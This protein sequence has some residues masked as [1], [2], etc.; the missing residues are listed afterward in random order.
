MRSLAAALV[1][2]ALTASAARA[3]DE[4]EH[5]HMIQALAQAAGFSAEA[6]KVIADGSWSMDKNPATTAFGGGQDAVDVA[7]AGGAVMRDP[8]YAT[9]LLTD[10]RALDAELF[11]P[12]GRLARIGPAALMHSLVHDPRRRP[13]DPIKPGLDA[14]YHRYLREQV[15][16]LEGRGV[17]SGDVA[18]VRLLLAGQYIHQF[19]DTFVH[20]E[21]PLV[22]HAAAG[23]TPDQ[24]WANAARLK[25]AAFVTLKELRILRTEMGPADD[26][27]RALR[28][29]T[30]ERQRAFVGGLVDA[31]ARGYGRESK[32]PVGIWQRAE[33]SRTEMVQITRNV[34]DY[35]NGFFGELGTSYRFR[36]ANFDRAAY[37][38]DGARFRLAY[39][40]LETEIDNFVPWLVG[41]AEYADIAGAIR[42]GM[43][44]HVE[45]WH[46]LAERLRALGHRVE[47]LKGAAGAALELLQREIDDLRAS[48]KA[49]LDAIARSYQIELDEMRAHRRET[50]KTLEWLAA[51]ARAVEEAERRWATRRSATAG[52]R[53]PD[54][55]GRPAPPP[56]RT[57]SAPPRS[58][59]SGREASSVRETGSRS[60]D[61]GGA[62]SGPR[63][64]RIDVDAIR[65][66]I[67]RITGGGF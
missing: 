55:D 8:A 53:P 28:L 46:R 66:R 63:E 67:N 60:R 33:I 7:L 56:V 31:I 21:D 65:S 50:A 36:V 20:P 51:E 43:R 41:R 18:R 64:R 47:T 30:D 37:V 14:A 23:H 39:R 13:G 59:G 44:R 22:G 61:D 24:A 25:A 62:S 27:L 35:M 32:T 10:D 40:G 15:R 6:A 42:A 2:L 45:A 58:S 57:S 9:A 29:D 34:E 1:A 26:R 12:G 4:P 48:R 49:W 16:G 11:R 5:R 17:P 19:V 52:L 3:G 38:P 54:V